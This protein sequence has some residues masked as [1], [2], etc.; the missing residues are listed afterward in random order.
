M[1]TIFEQ[2][3]RDELIS[4][5]NS[6]N[7][8]SAAQWGK[9]NVYQMVKHC[10]MWEEMINGDIKCK[11]SFLGRIFGRLALKNAVKDDRPMMMKAPSSPEVIVREVDGDLIAEKNKWIGLMEGHTHFSNTDFIHPFFG[12]M[13]KEE[14]G[15]FAYK[16]SDH[17]LRQFNG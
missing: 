10:R 9:M 7:E 15:Y 5:I 14:I 13:T 12:K 4:R 6:L 11:R 1:K 17:H 16:H 3:T 8:N 2:A